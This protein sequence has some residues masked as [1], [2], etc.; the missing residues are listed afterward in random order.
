MNEVAEI[1]RWYTERRQHNSAGWLVTNLSEVPDRARWRALHRRCDPEPDSCDDYWIDVSRIRAIE[2]V[3]VW[4][5]HLA[6]KTWFKHTSW[7]DDVLFAVIPRRA[8]AV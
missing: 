6:H 7:D 1:E 2:D 5:A 8:W 4:T 3:L